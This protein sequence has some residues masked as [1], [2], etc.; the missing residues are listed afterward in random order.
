MA[1][2]GCRDVPKRTAE[3]KQRRADEDAQIGAYVAAKYRLILGPVIEVARRYEAGEVDWSEFDAVIHGYTLVQREAWIFFQAKRHDLLRFIQEEQRGEEYW[4][5]VDA[6]QAKHTRR[7]AR[8]DAKHPPTTLAGAVTRLTEIARAD[9]RDDLIRPLSEWE[10]LVQRYIVNADFPGFIEEAG[11]LVAT[12]EAEA[13]EW[14]DLL[15]NIW[16][17]TPQP[18]RGGRTAL[19]LLKKAPRKRG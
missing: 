19:E 15:T 17:T 18:D 13:Q 16:N 14:T 11:G 8:Y 4:D 12:D 5:P 3:E 10:G 6:L 2:S 7:Q 1:S 9:G